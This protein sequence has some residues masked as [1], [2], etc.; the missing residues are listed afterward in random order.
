MGTG[1]TYPL[2][3]EDGPR[4]GPAPPILSRQRTVRS[5]DG[6]HLSSL[7]RGRSAV[8][9]GSAYPL[10][11]E[12]GPR[13]GPPTSCGSRPLASSSGDQ[14]PLSARGRSPMGTG[15]TYPLSAEDGP[16]WGPAPPVPSRRE[17]G[18][19]WGRAPPI[20]SRQRTSPMGTRQL[21]ERGP[22]S[23]AKERYPARPGLRPRPTGLRRAVAA[24]AARE[25]VRRTSGS[26]DRPA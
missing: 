23:P 11:A 15:S 18:P 21:A 3:A 16:R 13:W 19:R 2:P 9:T 1:S 20:L 5:G 4:W 26:A 17:D 10:S 22:W 14:G 8:G 6:L 25:P 7:G 12:D 24:P